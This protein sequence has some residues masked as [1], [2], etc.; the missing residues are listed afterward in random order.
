MRKFHFIFASKHFKKKSLSRLARWLTREASL[1]AVC[2]QA[3]LLKNN[4]ET[5]DKKWGVEQ[6]WNFGGI[7]SL[8]SAEIRACAS[9]QRNRIE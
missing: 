9:P 8:S 7:M 6:F 3:W 2:L 5:A 1:L 4:K